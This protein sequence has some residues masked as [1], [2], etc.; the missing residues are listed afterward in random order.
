MANICTICGKTFARKHDLRRH[1]NTVHKE[2]EEEDYNSDSSEMDEEGTDGSSNGEEMDTEPEGSDQESGDEGSKRLEDNAVFLQ[3]LDAAKDTTL[4]ARTEKYE[5]Y[6]S[7]GMD[8]AEATEKA[9]LRTKSDMKAD[10]FGHYETF[11]WNY[12]ML[13]DNEVHQEILA[14]IEEKVEE[15]VENRHAIKRA[16]AKCQHEFEGLFQYEPMEVDTSDSGSEEETA[17][18][19]LPTLRGAGGARPLY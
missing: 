13:E 2:E 1:G 10:F 14:A 19:Q 16:M 12:R 7:Q 15:G 6:V 3:W 5:K 4:Q 17:V 11:L 8:E 9:Y 18:P